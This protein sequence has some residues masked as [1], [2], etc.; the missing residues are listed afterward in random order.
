MKINDVYTAYISWEDGGKC[1][2]V[3]IVNVTNTEVRVFK[4]T[5]KYENKSQSIKNKY[6][7]IQD[8]SSAGLLKQSYIDTIKTYSLNPEKIKFKKIGKLSTE[9]ILELAKFINR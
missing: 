2:P 5:T 7:K 3:L 1:R 8:L 9:D 4:I 6:Y